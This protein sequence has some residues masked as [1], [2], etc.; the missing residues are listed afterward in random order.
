MLESAFYLQ[1]AGCDPLLYFFGAQSF[2]NSSCGDAYQT[3]GD[4]AWFFNDSRVDDI[5]YGEHPPAVQFAPAP[6]IPGSPRGV[7]V[8]WRNPVTAP[9][10]VDL[11]LVGRTSL[12]ASCLAPS[13]S[14]NADSLNSAFFGILLPE[15]YPLAGALGASYPPLRES[16]GGGGNG[17]VNPGSEIPE[18]RTALLAA[19]GLMLLA[20]VKR[21]HS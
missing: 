6:L 16:N 10:G 2:E 18:P 8:R 9:A 4:W 12:S 17:G 21:L 20:G 3:G 1:P 7:T 15:G 13:C 19:A 11:N 5:L 14:I